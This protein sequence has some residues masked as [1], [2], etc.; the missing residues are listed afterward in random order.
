MFLTTEVIMKSLHQAQLSSVAGGL[1]K[2]SSTLYI[3]SPGDK[4]DVSDFSIEYPKADGPS[5]EYLLNGNPVH[6]INNN[7]DNHDNIWTSPSVISDSFFSKDILTIQTD[8]NY[9]YVQAN[10]ITSV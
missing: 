1:H 3:L 8:M 5:N 9:L 2:T 10:V 7:P 6:C 4:I